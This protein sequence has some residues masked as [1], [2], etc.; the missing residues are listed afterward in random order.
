LNAAGAAP[1]D[2]SNDWAGCASERV[3]AL[4]DGIFAVTTT[5]LVLAGRGGLG[6]R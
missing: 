2:R 5:L 6:D 4:A 1:S 3:E